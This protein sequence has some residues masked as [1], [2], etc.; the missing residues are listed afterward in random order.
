MR[1]VARVE[2]RR[3]RDPGQ[4]LPELQKRCKRQAGQCP[5]PL[6]PPALAFVD[7]FAPLLSLGG[8][9][10]LSG[11]LVSVVDDLLSPRAC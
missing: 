1:G 9:C 2:G 8:L 7:L 10:A 4:A 3:E 6:P 11:T 5:F